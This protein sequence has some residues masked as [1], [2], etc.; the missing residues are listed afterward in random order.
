VTPLLCSNNVEPQIY[1]FLY[2][3]KVVWFLWMWL[4]MVNRRGDPAEL[5]ERSML[6]CNRVRKSFVRELDKNTP[7]RWALYVSDTWW[8]Q[9]IA[10]MDLSQRDLAHCR[11][12][13]CIWV[14]DQRMRFVCM[15]NCW[16]H[17]LGTAVQEADLGI[18]PYQEGSGQP[19]RIRETS[20]HR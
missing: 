10:A 5:Y 17:L 6:L 20:Q 1:A 4:H 8:W 16:M 11:T 18:Y 7:S 19:Y 12:A 3:M 13:D 2:S 14:S 15:S 9:S